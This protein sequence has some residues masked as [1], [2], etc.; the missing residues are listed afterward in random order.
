MM[1]YFTK[2]GVRATNAKVSQ[3]IIT[4]LKQEWQDYADTIPPYPD[5]F[6]GRGIVMCAGGL[7]YFTCAWVSI[8]VL[9]A[10]GCAL[11]IEV[12]YYGGEE[13][14]DETIA[15][16]EKFDV[17]CKNFLDYGVKSNIGFM[18]KP[19]AVMLSRFKEV[20]FLDADNICIKDPTNLFSFKEYLEYGAVFWPDYWRT[21][22][23]N[24]IWSITGAQMHNMQEQ[25][26]G[27][28]LINKEKCWRAL[29]LCVYFNNNHFFYYQFL[30]GDKDTF[31]FAWLALGTPF[32]WI[33]KEAGTCGYEMNGQFYGTTIVQHDPAD[34]ICFLHRNLSKWSYTPSEIRLWHKIKRFNPSNHPKDYIFEI[35]H[36]H[37]HS[38]MDLSGDVQ[39][40]DFTKLF[41]TF[42]ESCMSILNDLRSSDMYH[43][44]VTYTEKIKKPW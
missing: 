12:W 32:H 25:E 11:P 14:S 35:S 8:K 4:A 10:L 31:R 30:M 28:I 15:E 44:F 42:E 6:E 13:M 21:A 38:Y 3:E 39:L 2:D 23:D 1:H 17:Q 9:R 40:L 41:D 34:E 19:I 24:P 29:N 5:T 26:S 33:K 37:G 20:L 7:R 27:Q 22:P 16:L 36:E 43:R 18:L